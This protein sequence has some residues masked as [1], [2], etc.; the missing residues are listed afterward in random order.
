MY[1]T[2]L[3]NTRIY[4]MSERTRAMQRDIVMGLVVQAC[5]PVMYG[6]SALMYAIG[7]TNYFLKK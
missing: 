1:R 2:L 3:K 7:N 4:H 6:V 5:L